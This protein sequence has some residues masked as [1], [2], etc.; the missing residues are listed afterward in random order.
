MIKTDIEDT[1]Y[2]YL[3]ASLFSLEHLPKQELVLLL[4]VC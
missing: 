1:G 3:F 2:S 4:I